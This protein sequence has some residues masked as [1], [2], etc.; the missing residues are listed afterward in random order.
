VPSYF[1]R[2]IAA[3]V[4]SSSLTVQY[5]HAQCVMNGFLL[6]SDIKDFLSN[7]RTRRLELLGRTRESFVILDVSKKPWA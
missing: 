7:G 6:L 2:E 3:R 5:S 4:S 1:L